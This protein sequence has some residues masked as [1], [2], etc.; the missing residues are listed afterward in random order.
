VSGRVDRIFRKTGRTGP[1]TLVERTVHIRNQTGALVAEI[2]DRQVVRWKPEAGGER[3]TARGAERHDPLHHEGDGGGE[4]VEIGRLEIGDIL[5][6]FHRR[7]PRRL[8]ISRWA[9]SLRDRETLFHDR[10]GSHALGYD[11]LVVP[12]PMQS[13]FVDYL[14][15]TKLPDWRIARLSMTF[16]QSIL[17]GEALDIEGVVVD[18][19]SE[20]HTLDIVIRNAANGETASVGTAVLRKR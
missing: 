12:G 16:R 18:V 10:E 3:T 15:T 2:T 8:E 6:P 17:A 11:D 1:M 19:G 5:G 4:D 7:G 20:D 13:A 9:D 14:L